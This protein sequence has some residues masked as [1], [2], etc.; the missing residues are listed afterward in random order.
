MNGGEKIK[1]TYNSVK[2]IHLFEIGF[3]QIRN[4]L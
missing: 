2:L 3:R 1:N 4:F